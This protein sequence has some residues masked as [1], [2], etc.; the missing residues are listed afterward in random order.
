[1][2]VSIVS[3]VLWVMTLCSCSNIVKVLDFS[4]IIVEVSR[5]RCG[6]VL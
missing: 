5:V 1:M 6:Q 4:F 2:A 3:E